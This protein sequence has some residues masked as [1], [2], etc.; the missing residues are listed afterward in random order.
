MN[1]LY[2]CCTA[3]PWATV[4]HEL[5]NKW[6]IEAKYFVH[7]NHEGNEL[8]SLEDRGCFLHTVEDLWKGNGFPKEIA[9][10]PISPETRSAFSRYELIA[11]TMMDRLDPDA[12]SFSR[13]RREAFYLDLVGAWLY[14]INSYNI[15]LIISPTV[16]HRVFDYC[17]YV[18]AKIT[19]VE[20]VM[21]QMTPFD[22]NT[23]IISDIERLPEP[24]NINRTSNEKPELLPV[25]ERKITAV[26]KSY[27]D[28]IPD[29]MVQHDTATRAFLKRALL[30]PLQNLKKYRTPPNTYWVESGKRPQESH[31]SWAKF[32]ALHLK[33]L[34][35][36]LRL[37]AQYK[38]L[39]N[40]ISGKK[41][42]VFVALHYQPE[43][44]TCPTG[45]IYSNQIEI[46]RALVSSLPE[47]TEI[48]V[49]EHK[50]QFNFHV[51]AA[52][53]RD[54][55]YY[56]NILEL[57]KKITLA[58][59]DSDPFSLIDNAK[60]VVTVSGT[61]GWE[62]V[63]RGKPCLVFGR[64][65]YENMPGVAKIESSK[66]LKDSINSIETIQNEITKDQLRHFH[67]ELQHKLIMA[68]HYK[69]F[70]R[71]GVDSNTSAQ[72]LEK[73]IVRHLEL[74]KI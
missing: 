16:P 27:K 33:R 67:L 49:K 54:A 32:Y 74:E 7:W 64:A 38:T 47:E 43:E 6:K 19:G 18:A 71:K 22:S 62:A 5:S 48:I 65:W 73:A 52:S 30:V 51:E 61:V 59:V 1:A 69:A 14:V 8:K 29:Y 26:R 53:G 9:V 63:Q 56:K 68:N 31:I 25:I 12:R 70:S 57:S 40:E 24:K 28:A 36:V 21:L 46:I 45:G 15:N 20:I 3:T 35:M 60:F 42:Y 34:L 2:L 55:N 66:N 72:N 17:L 4:A 37:R 39:S 13:M 10:Q 58:P 41:D 44:T 11:M 50:T 23:F